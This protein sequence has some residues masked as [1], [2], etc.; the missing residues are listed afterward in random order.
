MKKIMAVFFAIFWFTGCFA[1]NELS[2]KEYAFVHG[3]EQFY[4]I[5]LGFD[6]DDSFYVKSVN[7][8]KGIY[9]VNGENL[10]MTITESTKLVPDI[11]FVNIERDF[12]NALARVKNFKVTDDGLQLIMIDNRTLNFRYA[13]KV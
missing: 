2:G 12:M 5:Y 4:P 11:Q 3:S 8:I 6:S 13:G 10:A 9:N 7:N 1:S